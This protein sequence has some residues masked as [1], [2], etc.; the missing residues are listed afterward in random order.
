MM[1]WP[2]V[3]QTFDARSAAHEVFTFL[4]FVAGMSLFSAYKVAFSGPSSAEI[5]EDFKSRLRVRTQAWVMVSIGPALLVYVFLLS[6]VLQLGLTF[7]YWGVL[8]LVVY[9][10][11]VWIAVRF[12]FLSSDDVSDY[13]LDSAERI[14]IDEKWARQN[15]G[16]RI[17]LYELLVWAVLL[18]GAIGWLLYLAD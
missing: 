4:A 10:L 12:F 6:P 9:L 7:P 15:R 16:K 2:H 18:I 11:P 1:N 14:A 17:L 5:G 3:S 8:A 13:T